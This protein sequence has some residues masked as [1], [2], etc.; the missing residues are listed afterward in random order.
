MIEPVK[1]EQLPIYLNILRESYEET[2]VAFGMTEENC[3]YRGRTRLPLAVLE[4]EW[5]DGA[6]MFGYLCEGKAVGFLSMQVRGDVLCIQDIA[7]L[8]GYQNRGSG[9]EL[10][11]FAVETA[12]NAG[13]GKISLG[14]VY[15]NLRLRQWYL[16]LGFTVRELLHFDKVNY[17]VAVLEREI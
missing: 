1:W 10:F 11:A 15:D 16:G 6:L 3:P 5:E 14:M 17:V 4:Q 7:V 13:A 12:K 2:A 9:G 8:P